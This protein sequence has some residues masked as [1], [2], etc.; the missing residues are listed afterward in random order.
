M[1]LRLLRFDVSKLL[2]L[3]QEQVIEVLDGDLII[4]KR[5]EVA[6]AL[7]N[8]SEKLLVEGALLGT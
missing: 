6:L 5:G 7:F 1:R 3:I 8:G 2:R 4:S